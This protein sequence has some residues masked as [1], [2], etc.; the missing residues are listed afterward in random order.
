MLFG[1]DV[2]VCAFLCYLHPAGF[3]LKSARIF[4]LAALLFAG[5]PAFAQPQATQT[6]SADTTR[7]EATQL[8][9]A[10]IRPEA[11]KLRWEKPAF[12]PW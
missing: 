8:Q 4:C 2:V 11:K 10:T 12:H 5:G 9:P 1:L 7:T 3:A 6:Q